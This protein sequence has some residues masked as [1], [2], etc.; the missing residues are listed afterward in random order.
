MTFFIRLPESDDGRSSIIRVHDAHPGMARRFYDLFM[1]LMSRPGP[2]LR[3]QRELIATV[4]AL[5]NGC[6]Y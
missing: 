2:L 1:E 5:D 6:R 3:W 4:V